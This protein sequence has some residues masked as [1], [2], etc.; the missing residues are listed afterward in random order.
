MA[1]ATAVRTENTNNVP[2]EA[3]ARCQTLART[4]GTCVSAICAWCYG[5]QR[6]LASTGRRLKVRACASH[7][8]YF[9]AIDE[10]I[11]H[12][13]GPS[14]EPLPAAQLNRAA[15]HEAADSVGPP[16]AQIHARSR[17]ITAPVESESASYRRNIAF[18]PAKRRSIH[19]TR[20]RSTTSGESDTP[21]SKSM[22]DTES[23]QV[24]A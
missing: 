19:L 2:T 20:G 8:A 17:R 10:Q 23:T 22:Q 12:S 3:R 7:I 15:R 9:F 16:S 18:G 14:R 5:R 21:D 4:A 13:P 6:S 24:L 11:G 1:G